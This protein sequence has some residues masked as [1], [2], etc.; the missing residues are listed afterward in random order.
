MRYLFMKLSNM[1]LFQT[2]LQETLDL[3][4]I[5]LFDWLEEFLLDETRGDGVLLLIMSIMY[6]FRFGVLLPSMVWLT[7]PSSSLSTCD[8]V[9]VKMNPVQFYSAGKIENKY[10]EFPN[11]QY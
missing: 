5:E 2:H 10:L 11:E 8:I 3:H 6:N 7:D 9:L 4:G 1:Y